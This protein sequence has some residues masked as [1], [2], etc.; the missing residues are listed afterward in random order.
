MTAKVE[1][2]ESES[3]TSHWYACDFSRALDSQ[4]RPA[5]EECTHHRLDA[6]LFR[7]ALG[8]LGRI[9][10]TPTAFGQHA[11]CRAEDGTGAHTGR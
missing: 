2:T 6:E 10:R 9:F 5:R 8:D 4:T 11:A 1:S 3:E 7:D